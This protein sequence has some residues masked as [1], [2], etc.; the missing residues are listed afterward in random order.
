MR[1]IVSVMF[2]AQPVRVVMIKDEPWFVAFDVGRVL[3]HSQ[4][5]KVVNKLDEDERMMVRIGSVTENTGTTGKPLISNN[6]AKSPDLG[7]SGGQNPGSGGQVSSG[8]MGGNPNYLVV[9]ESG[10]YGLIF[11]SELPS[12]RRFRRWVTGEVLPQIRRTGG[13]A[14]EGRARTARG[15]VQAQ[16]MLAAWERARSRPVSTA[17]RDARTGQRV[18]AVLLAEALMAQGW[19]A[20]DALADA[21]G[22]VEAAPATVRKWMEK[23]RGTDLMELGAVLADAWGRRTVALPDA[24]VLG[25]LMDELAEPRVSFA[26]AARQV[27]ARAAREGWGAA[28]S[29]RTL[30]RWFERMAGA[31]VGALE[32]ATGQETA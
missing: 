7:T 31:T 22:E 6:L 21:A 14:P 23:A 16:R 3:G 20:K 17:R 28:P 4:I 24:R 27:E 25:A 8:A 18:H 12:A 11:L 30:R 1:D 10:L 15:E 26:A 13:Y 19:K 5:R 32:D 2:E 9:S 29:E